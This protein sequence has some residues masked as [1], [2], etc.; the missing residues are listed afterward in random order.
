MIYFGIV[1]QSVIITFSFQSNIFL[2]FYV[3]T[4]NTFAKLQQQKNTRIIFHIFFRLNL[5]SSEEDFFFAFDCAQANIWVEIKDL[6]KKLFF[7]F[8]FFVSP[9]MDRVEHGMWSNSL[10]T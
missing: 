3:R 7:D 5:K 9:L 10:I 8:K 4:W 1:G 2:S 6:K